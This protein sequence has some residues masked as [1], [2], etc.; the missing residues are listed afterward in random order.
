MVSPEYSL[1]TPPNPVRAQLVERAEDWRWSSLGGGDPQYKLPI[2][3][4]PVN[5]PSQ[6]KRI[7]NNDF[8]PAPLASLRTSVQR[9]RPFGTE[10]WVDA[11]ARRLKITSTL[12]GIGRPRRD[13]TAAK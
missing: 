1:N 7:V 12:N 10:A 11:T 9:G 6:W 8:E 5:R 4:W 13:A 3:A 2:G